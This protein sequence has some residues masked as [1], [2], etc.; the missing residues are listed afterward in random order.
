MLSAKHGQIFPFRVP[1]IPLHKCASSLHDHLARII[2]QNSRCDPVGGSVAC[3]PPRASSGY[4]DRNADSTIHRN[5]DR[6][7]V[8]PPPAFKLLRVYHRGWPT[9]ACSALTRSGFGSVPQPIN[10]AAPSI[11]TKPRR[12]GREQEGRLLG[13]ASP[14]AR[15]PQHAARAA[16]DLPGTDGSDEI[17]HACSWSRLLRWRCRRY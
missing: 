3:A 14:R 10:P 15:P 6:A 7:S 17:E 2:P 5:V 16:I 9:T 13:S 8:E 12:T 1:H 4:E 11:P